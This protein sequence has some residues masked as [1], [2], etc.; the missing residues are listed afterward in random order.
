MGHL[1]HFSLPIRHQRG[2]IITEHLFRGSVG[3][4]LAL[5]LAAAYLSAS[6]SVTLA[7][8][9]Y[10]RVESTSVGGPN[11]VRDH[12]RSV[13]ARHHYNPGRQGQVARSGPKQVYWP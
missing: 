4:R 7:H 5:A 11:Y 10:A 9:I 1:F 6:R 8:D 12:F 2:M 13:Q 3:S